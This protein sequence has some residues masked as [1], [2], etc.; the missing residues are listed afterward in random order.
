MRLPSASSATHSKGPDRGEGGGGRG[1]VRGGL[2]I[3]EV[4]GGWVVYNRGCRHVAVQESEE[5]ERFIK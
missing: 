3:D 2:F 5:E 4:A 1:G